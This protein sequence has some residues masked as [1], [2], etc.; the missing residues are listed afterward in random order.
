MS[1]VWFGAWFSTIYRVIEDLKES[2]SKIEFY[3]I[4]TNT[5]YEAVYRE[6]CDEWYE[7]IDTLDPNKYIDWALEFCKIHNVDIFIP[8]KKVNIP[9]HLRKNK[10]KE[11]DIKDDDYFGN[12]DFY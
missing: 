12:F 2:N 6:I 5:N 1:R 11:K 7:E 10:K 4:G 3:V 9:M 8:R